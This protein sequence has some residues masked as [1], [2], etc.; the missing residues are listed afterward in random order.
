MQPQGEPPIANQVSLGQGVGHYNLRPPLIS[1]C[2]VSPQERE[3]LHQPYKT[4]FSPQGWTGFQL[5]GGG[6]IEPPG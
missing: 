4:F 5:G 3:H 6:S 1:H 2:L